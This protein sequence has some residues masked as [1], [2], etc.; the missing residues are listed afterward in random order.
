MFILAS[1]LNFSKCTTY[2]YLL[3]TRKSACEIHTVHVAR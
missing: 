2:V 1:E 3:R